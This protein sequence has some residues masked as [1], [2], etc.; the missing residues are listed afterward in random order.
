MKKYVGM[1][2]I[3]PDSLTPRRLPHATRAMKN[4]EIGTRYGARASNAEV[5]AAVPAD[6]DTATV[7]M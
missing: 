3:R 5:R 7:R 6:A 1:A 2:K 4:S